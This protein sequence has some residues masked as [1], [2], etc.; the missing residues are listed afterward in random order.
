MTPATPT[1][2]LL[3]EVT[4]QLGFVAQT[5]MDIRLP[6]LPGCSVLNAR[7]LRVDPLVDVSG[8]A[9]FATA[10]VEV[11]VLQGNRLV[12]VACPPVMLRAE[13]RLRG[14]CNSRVVLRDADVAV[15]R[16]QVQQLPLQQLAERHLLLKGLSPG[17]QFGLAI[18]LIGDI[19]GDGVSDLAIGAPSIFGN[20]SVF[21]VSSSTG[22]VLRRID[23]PVPR[24]GFGFAIALAGDINADGLPDILVG[25]PGPRGTGGS[26]YLVST[27]T[28]AILRT[29]SASTSFDLFGW[30]VANPADVDGDGIP[31]QLIG[32]PSASPGGRLDAGSAFL[33]SGATGTLIHRYDGATAGDALGFA[34]GSPGDVTGDGVPELLLGA[35]QAS[36]GGVAQ[37]GLALLVGARPPFATLRSF[38]GT[39]AGDGLGWLVGAAGDLN[40][41]GVPDL[42]IGA[43][44]TAPFGGARPGR[45]SFFSGADGAKLR[46]LNG[47]AVGDS[48]GV[49]AAAANLGDIPFQLVGSPDAGPALSTGRADL[50]Q[51]ANP[52]PVR[53]FFGRDRFGQ[54]GW[55]VALD[56]RVLA[57]GAPGAD[58][59]GLDDAGTVDVFIQG[60]GGAS[61]NLHLGLCVEA[62]LAVE[63]PRQL[64]VAA[65]PC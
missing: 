50:F 36:P 22:N 45:L 15:L 20:G 59:D 11:E 37:A 26:A 41:D 34:V 7:V 63:Q 60:G 33:F 24:G 3:T 19:D 29:Y 9:C 65:A 48:L 30:S 44:G 27:R 18:A 61:C 49:A 5:A 10:Q 2:L 38:T 46:E 4:D 52:V 54:F 32:S 23:G 39:F 56:S 57:V 51:N 17:D 6:P 53:S 25:A 31:D 62:V 28:G 55:S 12:V 40:G 43:P 16:Q 1:C 13:R 42:M 21:L 8:G 64:T 35:S 47:L 14:T 58:P